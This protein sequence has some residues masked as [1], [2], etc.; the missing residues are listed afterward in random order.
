LAATAVHHLVDYTLEVPIISATLL[1][2]IASLGKY[3]PSNI[4]LRLSSPAVIRS[5]ALGILI[6]L[7]ANFYP[8][9]QLEIS[10]GIREY[11]SNPSQQS[12]EKICGEA[13]SH[14]RISYYQFE[15]GRVL[16]EEGY[17]SGDRQ[18]LIDAIQHI[19]IGLETDPYWP[20]HWANLA[21]LE[22]QVGRE[23]DALLHMQTA[24]TSAPDF[25]IFNMNYGWMLEQTGDV[26]RAIGYY[27][28]AVASD[29]LILDANFF[30][31]T[32][33]HPDSVSADQLLP[34]N[35][36]ASDYAFRGWYYVKLQEWELAR[37]E[38]NRAVATN[39]THPLGR[40][41]LALLDLRDGSLAA[42][43]AH[44][45]VALDSGGNS[46]INLV[47]GQVALEN[48]EIDQAMGFFERAYDV[49]RLRTYSDRYY[50]VVYRLN[51]ITPDN[52]PQLNSVFI[53]DE[54]LKAFYALAEYKINNQEVDKGQAIFR[55][56]QMWVDFGSDKIILPELE[57]FA[58][59]GALN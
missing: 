57:I 50:A 55:N 47:A 37:E 35:F 52:V 6:I 17:R 45:N 16:A 25:F 21:A 18:E 40:A 43:Q 13:N 46:T 19:N 29:P 8:S 33:F 26:D 2:M 59:S 4:E 53:N 12:I 36:E 7:A 27:S 54:M 41:G 44:I 30:K 20:M 38:L 32:E 51:Y 42:S 10:E 9:G 11:S 23:T 34:T 49:Y 48:G 1:F 24:L 56:L 58:K 3:S 28:R 39:P 22:W 31:I 5:L 14:Q 15:C